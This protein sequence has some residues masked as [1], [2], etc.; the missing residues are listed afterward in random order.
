MTRKI[1]LKSLNDP[2]DTTTPQGRLTFNL[3]ASLA[4]FD[5]TQSENGPK[6]ACRLRALEGARAAGQKGCPATP[7]RRLARPRHFIEKAS[8]AAEKSPANFESQKVLCIPTYATAACLS[9]FIG[10]STVGDQTV[11]TNMPKKQ[12]VGEAL[13]DLHR[14]LSALPSRS[15]D[16]RIIM[17]ETAT[18]VRCI[19]EQ[20]LYRALAE[21]ARPR[22][23]RRSDRGTPRVLPQDKMESYCEVI[24]GD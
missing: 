9:A 4:E 23:L 19:S 8:S 7:N 22:A 21:R 11:G 16:R 14:R 3:F 1:G 17:R 18:P 24:A 6:P 20:T 15:H 13:I 10:R 12:L 5:A 2:I